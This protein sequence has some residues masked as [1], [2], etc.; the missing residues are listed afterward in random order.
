MGHRDDHVPLLVTLLD[1]P[2][3]LDHLLERIGPVDDR[4]QL[5]GLDEILEED[6]VLGLDGPSEDRL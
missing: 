2:E 3:C 6:K 1:V 5:S 4:L